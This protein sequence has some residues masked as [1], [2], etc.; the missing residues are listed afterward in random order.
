MTALD[1]D[2]DLLISYGWAIVILAIILG[3]IWWDRRK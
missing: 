3:L 2:M 1:Y